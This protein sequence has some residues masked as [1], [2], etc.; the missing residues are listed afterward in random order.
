MS[1]TSLGTTMEDPDLE[2]IRE[3][4]KQRRKYA[5]H[6]E[7][8]RA[9]KHLKEVGVVRC[10]IES[11]SKDSFCEYRNLRPCEI[12]PPDCLANNVDG[13]L[14]GFEVRELVDQKAIELNERGEEVYR[15][16]TD[17]EII[18]EVAAIL[19]EKDSKN[20]VTEHLTKL[21]LV[22]PT[23]EPDLD[24]KHLMTVLDSHFLDQTEQFD[25]AYLLFQY[26]SAAQGYPYIRLKIE[27]NPR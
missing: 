13:A 15:H 11:I 10:L 7:W 9:E 17:V 25:E 4:I 21:I 18:E 3:F 20:Y 23:A 6:F 16:W 2:T 14:V 5:S 22:I 27:P 1:P 24:H 19:K 26:D 12:D 8:F